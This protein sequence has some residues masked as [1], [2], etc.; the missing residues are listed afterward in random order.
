MNGLRRAL[1]VA[2][3]ALL[4]PVASLLSGQA[5][6][7]STG[8]RERDLAAI[9]SEVARLEVRLGEARSRERDLASFLAAAELEL[10]LQERRVAEA[11]AARRVAEAAVAD[12]EREVVRLADDLE[13]V[14]TAL[15]DRIGVLYRLGRNGPLRL[16]L[17]VEAGSDLPSAVRLLR[18]L[19]RRDARAIERYTGL[20]EELFERRRRL[21][22]E[23]RE[24]E[25]WLA[26]AQTRRTEVAAAQRR[27]ARLL[28]R[29]R[30]ERE[31]LARRSEELLDKERKLAGLIASLRGADEALAGAPID[32]FRGVLDWPVPGEVAIGFGPRTDPRYRT[33]VP[34]NGVEIVPGRE[35][36]RD[37]KGRVRVLAVYPGKVLYAAPFEGYGRTVVVHHAGRV[38]T[39]YADLDELLV[40]PGQLLELGA[41]VGTASGSV[42]FE[43]RKENRPEDPLRW[44]R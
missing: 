35:A 18:F 25:R 29:A 10:E 15:R 20:R 21:E 8:A 37:G 24:V 36:G 9:R 6:E 34:H 19:V 42:Y 22:A 4:L 11:T 32:R 16:V 13:A 43:V 31:T 14:R 27:Q 28:E 38:F 39:L 2:A 44:L 5:P 3:A 7:A 17:G 41:P 33:Q 30:I 1:A 40:A 12:T 26:E 23:R